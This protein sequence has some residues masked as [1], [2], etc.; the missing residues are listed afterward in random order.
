M[1]VKDEGSMNGM[2]VFS[3]DGARYM[4]TGTSDGKTVLMKTNSDG[5][6]VAKMVSNMPFTMTAT[7]DIEQTLA[8][9]G[10]VFGDGA[11]E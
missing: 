4:L 7:G 9:Y 1:E 10:F 5:L 2:A 8:H 11:V 6:C 3:V